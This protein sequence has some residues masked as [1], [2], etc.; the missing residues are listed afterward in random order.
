MLRVLVETTQ[1]LSESY[2]NREWIDSFA[3]EFLEAD[4]AA[5]HT[6]ER[7]G[8]EHAD[9]VRLEKELWE[10]IRGQMLGMMNAV[11]AQFPADRQPL[12]H[13]TKEA[14]IVGDHDIIIRW[15]L[16]AT[17]GISLRWQEGRV[18]Y[19]VT[20][21]AG[22]HSTTGDSPIQIVGG[23]AEL[24]KNGQAVADVGEEFLKPWVLQ[25]QPVKRT[26]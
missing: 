1:A 26:T 23:R 2:M 6:A 24:T 18:L 13:V 11:N 16:G 25:F 19:S 9:R 5:R 14:G 8:A 17:S 10:R 12:M 4:N 20:D 22:S 21:A 3:K 7:Q 15:R